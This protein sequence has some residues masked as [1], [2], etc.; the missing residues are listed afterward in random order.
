ML[1]IRRRSG[2]S[3]DVRFDRITD[4]IANLSREGAHGPAL[5]NADTTLVAQKVVAGIVSGMTTADLDD[6]AAETSVAMQT[7]HPD[8]GTLAARIAVAALHK[9][10]QPSFAESV[11]LLA[12]AGVVPPYPPN[13]AVDSAIDHSRDF[14][15]SY[16]GIKTLMKSYLLR[17]DGRVVARPQHM[18]M[19]VALGIWNDDVPA[20]VEQYEYMSRGMYTH[21]SQTLFNIGTLH[22]QGSSCFLLTIKDDPC[23]LWPP[24]CASGWACVHA[25]PLT[26]RRRRRLWRRQR[27]R[28]QLVA[29]PAPWLWA[30]GGWGA[31]IPPP[32]GGGGGDAPVGADTRCPPPELAPRR[33][34]A[35]R[36]R[37][38]AAAAEAAGARASSRPRRWAQLPAAPPPARLSSWPAAWPSAAAPLVS[39]AAQ[40]AAGAAFVGCGC[41]A[42]AS[43]ARRHRRRRRPP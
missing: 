27:R 17:V 41:A 39:A 25:V 2:V 36:V 4:Y 37:L 12:A 38:G 18:L 15:Y 19:R 30:L 34:P 24:L 11:R 7:V 22:Q 31:P 20:A 13:D 8:Y 6:L 32:D 16:F 43:R 26:T 9:D 14:G 3:E 40:A 42:T 35:L 28:R 5:P 21:A 29:A 23:P 33:R 10:T 1:Q